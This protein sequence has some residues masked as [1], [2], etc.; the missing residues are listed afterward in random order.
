MSSN[1]STVYGHF[2]IEADG[3][4]PGTSNMLSVA[5]VFTNQIGETLDE[6][7]IDIQPRL[8][9]PGNADTKLW[10]SHPDR[11]TEYN[12]ILKNGINP[13]DAMK[14]IND[15]IEEVMSKNKVKRITWV[16]RPAAYDWMWLKCYSD[17]YKIHNPNALDLGFSATCTSTMRDIWKAQNSISGT[18][19]E[20]I[21]QEW[22]KELKMTHNALDDS[23]FQATIFHKLQSEL[24]SFSRK[25]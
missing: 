8:G 5:F 6:M 23:R 16:A 19:A 17:M 9:F 13:I 4:S 14:A 3:P 15:K 18:K 2:D 11:I 21:F 24:A 1:S 10:W 20:E 25:S 22:A 12:R 7:L